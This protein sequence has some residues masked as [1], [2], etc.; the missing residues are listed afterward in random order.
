MPAA[1]LSISSHHSPIFASSQWTPRSPTSLKSPTK[2][3]GPTLS[4]EGGL[5]I[6]CNIDHAGA[7][8]RPMTGDI[9][10]DLVPGVSW[11]KDEA[12]PF[13]RR[14]TPEDFVPAFDS[15]MS[16]SSR[17]DSVLDV[18]ADM[19]GEFDDEEGEEDDLSHH[20]DIY[21]H[22]TA[23]TPTIDLDAETAMR[24]PEI[25][26]DRP[27]QRTSQ[28]ISSPVSSVRPPV[29]TTLISLEDY[30]PLD[31][32]QT[33]P[34]DERG[35]TGLYGGGGRGADNHETGWVGAPVAGAGV[36]APHGAIE[37]DLRYDDEE[38]DEED[39]SDHTHYDDD[40]EEEED[41]DHYI[42]HTSSAT[43]RDGPRSSLPTP[44]G[45][46]ASL[47]SIGKNSLRQASV[48]SNRRA[49]NK[50][51]RS[52]RQA[53]EVPIESGGYL[54]YHQSG[55]ISESI[56]A[57]RRRQMSQQD[58]LTPAAEAIR[59]PSP[60]SNLVVRPKSPSSD[61]TSLKK[62]DVLEATSVKLVRPVSEEKRKAPIAKIPE[63]LIPHRISRPLDTDIKSN[64][65]AKGGKSSFRWGIRSKKAPVISNPILPDGFVESLGMETFEL[66]P[67]CAASDHRGN[68]VGIGAGNKSSSPGKP[69]LASFVPLPG[70]KANKGPAPQPRKVPGP[71]RGPVRVG[72]PILQSSSFERVSTEDTV[73]RMP[74][75]CPPVSPT[76]VSPAGLQVDPVPAALINVVNGRPS[77]G[78]MRQSDVSAELSDAFHRLSRNSELSYTPSKSSSMDEA[79]RA[80]R[81]YFD[82]LRRNTHEEVSANTNTSIAF[83]NTLHPVVDTSQTATPILNGRADD[84]TFANPWGA[85]TAAS[86]Q[87]TFSSPSG[88]QYFSTPQASIASFESVLAP[89]STWNVSERMAHRN[90]EGSIY[91]TDGDANGTDANNR[92]SAYS[93]YSYGSYYDQTPASEIPA[94]P[95]MPIH[96]L[97]F[98]KRTDSPAQ[99]MDHGT[100]RPP[101]DARGP[102]EVSVK[103]PFTNETFYNTPAQMAGPP[104]WRTAPQIGTTGFRNPFG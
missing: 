85:G 39:Y 30:Q 89:A 35:K 67:G 12:L 8:Y 36:V 91:S 104:Q 45:R 77:I 69:L 40:D 55:S 71:T 29:T 60:L 93:G 47:S 42:N 87:R 78:A 43:P 88:N 13:R 94:V 51:S 65:T 80:R 49:S 61:A 86:H 31:N 68:D 53:S 72:S 20:V 92:A 24:T 22:Y 17:I 64:G 100:S 81:A 66:T 38:D 27:I 96:P 3:R 2:R 82:G 103:A 7:S 102:S 70:S 23:R 97:K 10:Q 4:S 83:N 21:E 76:L 79:E 57:A 14:K 62:V 19:Y 90:S 34:W 101:F 33:R 6:S 95:I 50:S 25:A 84:K 52:V 75:S 58:K 48:S 98:A 15:A 18:Y 44:N 56:S 41:Y 74:I 59:Q 46:H 5:A 54:D 11:D 37:E 99:A 1:G 28:V 9:S 63:I 16:L 73:T 32:A 26:R